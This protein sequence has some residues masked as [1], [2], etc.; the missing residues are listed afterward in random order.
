[1]TL[2]GLLVGV[3]LALF[4]MTGANM[5][6]SAEDAGLMPPD[7][8]KTETETAAHGAAFRIKS[9]DHTGFTVSSLDD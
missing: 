2:S 9:I 7:R 1:M 3:T 8:A 6:A 5:T 4:T